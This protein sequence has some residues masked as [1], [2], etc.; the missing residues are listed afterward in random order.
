MPTKVGGLG[1][2]WK[3]FGREL[4]CRRKLAHEDLLEP[5]LLNCVVPLCENLFVLLW[6]QVAIRDGL[7]I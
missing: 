3:R 2:Q 7:Q 1:V 5:R 6:E 4:I